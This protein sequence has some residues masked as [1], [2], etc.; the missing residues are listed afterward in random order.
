MMIS[1]E[2]WQIENNV[3]DGG[4][5]STKGPLTYRTLG[6]IFLVIAQGDAKKLGSLQTKFSMKLDLNTDIC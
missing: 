1:S 4:H 6:P 2:A 3:Q 5:H